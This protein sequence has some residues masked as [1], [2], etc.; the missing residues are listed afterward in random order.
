M[1]AAIV[2]TI[3]GLVAMCAFAVI[4]IDHATRWTGS[5]EDPRPFRCDRCPC[6]FRDARWLGMHHKAQHPDT[7]E[8]P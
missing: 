4:A 6:S 1:T 5:V 2:V 8:A 3:L 7:Y